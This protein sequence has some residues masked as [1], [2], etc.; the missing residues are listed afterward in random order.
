MTH[1]YSFFSHLLWPIYVPVAVRLI[2][3]PG[4]RR[5]ALLAFVVAGCA[6]SLY[7]LFFLIALPVVAQPTGQHIEYVSPHFFAAAA[8]TFYLRPT[9]VSLLLSTHRVVKVF[10]ALALLS[11]GAAYY[12]YAR[13]FILVWCL[14]AALMSAV[15]YLHFE[16]RG[17][18]RSSSPRP[19]AATESDR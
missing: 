17:A 18:A 9:S 12:L 13:W 10:G 6:V 3:P 5:Q 11:F 15:I 8:M 1:A 19:L 14:F 4:R 16:R 7:L 2:E